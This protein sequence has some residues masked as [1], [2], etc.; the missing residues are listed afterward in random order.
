MDSPACRCTLNYNNFLVS[1]AKK[2]MKG[3]KGENGMFDSYTGDLPSL[4]H[5]CKT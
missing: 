3:M 2:V 5:K 4:Y 1:W